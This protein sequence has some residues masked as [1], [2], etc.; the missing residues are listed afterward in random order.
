MEWLMV[1][2]IYRA[3]HW[4]HRFHIPVLPRMLYVFN[5]I[6][7]AIALPPSAQLGKNVVLGY[8]GLGIVIHRRAV[9]GNCVNIGARVTIGGR[10]GQADVPVIEDE[11]MIGTGAC[12]LGPVRIGRNAQIGA[13]AVVLCDVPPHGVAVGVPARIVRIGGRCAEKCID[14]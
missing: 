10:S 1:L 4:L 8:R 14:C 7:F 12:I 9:I 2:Q 5:R 13:N 11:V 3:A 6:V